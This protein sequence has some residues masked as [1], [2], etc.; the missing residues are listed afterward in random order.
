MRRFEIE[1]AVG[2]IIRVGD[3]TVAVVDLHDE[4]VTLKIVASGD[5]DWL[6]DE[7]PVLPR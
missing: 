4:E 7:A 2:D 3:H 1:L 5:D 6:V